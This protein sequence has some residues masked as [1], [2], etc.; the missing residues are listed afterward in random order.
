MFTPLQTATMLHIG[1]STLRKYA[2]LYRDH[3]SE[4][5]HHKQRTYTDLD[6]AILKRIVDMRATGVPLDE[7]SA[8]LVIVPAP[9][10]AESSL[11]MLPVIS[12]QFQN[13]FDKLAEQQTMINSLT[14]R[15]DELESRSLWQR[16]FPPRRTPKT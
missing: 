10:S 14:Q 9:T 16:I 4:T 8:Q 1:S 13:L 2:T 15:I 12:E 5:A 3:L 11:A 6:I 7:I